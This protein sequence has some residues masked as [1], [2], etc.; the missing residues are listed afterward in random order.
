MS[1]ALPPEAYAAALAALKEMTL[2]RLG[3]LLRGREPEAA[4]AIVEGR[5]PA[6]GLVAKVVAQP[7]VRSAWERSARER[8]PERIWHECAAAGITVVRHGGPGYPARLEVDT[9]PPPVLFARGDLSLLDGR[10]VGLVGTR[11]A[12]ASGRQAARRLAAGLAAAGVH[13]V[14]GLA[15]GIDGVAHGAVVAAEREGRPVGVVATGL[16]TVYPREHRDLWEAVANCGLLLS[17]AP[18]GLGPAAYRFPLRNRIIAA[19]SE[20]VVVVESRHRGGSLITAAEAI[21]RGV[22]VMAVPGPPSNPASGGTNDLLRDGAAPA[23]EVDD[24]LAA[25]SLQAV[26]VPVVER[27]ARPRAG[28]LAVYDA[29]RE[30]PCTIDSVALRCGSS[31]V[32][33]AMSLARLEQAGWVAASDGWYECVGSPL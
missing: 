23:I 17:E 8:P 11:N 21:E 5:A 15:R 13:V 16:D 28:D 20:V 7:Q 24:V 22:P 30:A 2:H 18:P 31:L 12:T 32:E 27:R 6:D 33:A 1:G 9:A 25:L 3:A 29:V 19:L 4:W 10:C 14:S 26:S